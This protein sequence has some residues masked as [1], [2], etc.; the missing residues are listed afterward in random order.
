MI[1]I[2]RFGRWNSHHSRHFVFERVWWRG[3]KWT[4]FCKMRLR[5]AK[6]AERLHQISIVVF[7]ATTAII[8]GIYVLAAW[9]ILR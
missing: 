9:I 1:I 6:K 3:Y 8:I 4:P 5:S 7:V 2:P